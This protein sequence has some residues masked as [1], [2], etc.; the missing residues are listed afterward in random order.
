MRDLTK[1]RSR[2]SESLSNFAE[3]YFPWGELKGQ[4]AAKPYRSSVNAVTEMFDIA[5]NMAV[6][7]VAL[8]SGGE[9]IIWS[10]LLKAFFCFYQE[11]TKLPT[12]LAVSEHTDNALSEDFD[13]QRLLP[14]R[15]QS[16]TY[17]NFY[18]VNDPDWGLCYSENGGHA[19]RGIFIRGSYMDF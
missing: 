15:C 7:A 19:C 8:H 14:L 1:E 3:Q 10:Q 11:H 12:G 2:E 18:L 17:L 16:S 5:S 6:H 4:P 13:T 9:E